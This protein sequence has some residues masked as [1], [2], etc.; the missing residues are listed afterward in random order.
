M[1][2]ILNLCFDELRTCNINNKNNKIIKKN[3]KETNV[4][5]TLVSILTITVH[6][7]KSIPLIFCNLSTQS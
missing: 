3:G 1:D 5:F 2:Q 4:N 6:K 7:Q